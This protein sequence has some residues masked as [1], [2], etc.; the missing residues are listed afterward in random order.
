MISGIPYFTDVPNKW[1]TKKNLGI[2][3]STIKDTL[4]TWT[5]FHA[6]HGASFEN[7]SLILKTKGQGGITNIEGCIILLCSVWD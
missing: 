3:L 1:A 2:T 5:D 4:S 6:E 7:T